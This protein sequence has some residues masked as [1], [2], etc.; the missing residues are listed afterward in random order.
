MVTLKAGKIYLQ[1]RALGVTL[2]LLLVKP[3]CFR[4]SVLE[5]HLRAKRKKVGCQTVDAHPTG[6]GGAALTQQSHA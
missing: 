1:S 2:S 5:P 4:V 6:P 3:Q